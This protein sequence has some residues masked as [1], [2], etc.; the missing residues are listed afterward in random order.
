M[1]NLFRMHLLCAVLLALTIAFSSASGQENDSRQ[2]IIDLNQSIEAQIA[3]L[4]SRLTGNPDQPAERQ[5]AYH[6]WLIELYDSA[7]RPDDVMQSFEKIVSFFPYDVGILN[8]YAQYMLERRHDRDAAESLI[9]RARQFA[10]LIQVTD[11]DRGT[12]LYL[13]ASIDLDKKH[14]SNAISEFTTAAFLCEEAPGT[15]FA[16]LSGLT[17]A[18]SLAGRYQEAADAY[19]SLLGQKEWYDSYEMDRLRNLLNLAGTHQ[20][21]T[22]EQLIAAAVERERRKR[23]E[24]IEQEGAT[25]VSLATSRGLPL[26]GTLYEGRHPGAVIYLAPPAGTRMAFRLFSQLLFTEEISVLALDLRNTASTAGTSGAET[27]SSDPDQAQDAVAAAVSFMREKYALAGE[28]VVIISEGSVC[29]AVELAL[30]RHRLRCPVL[31]LSP[32]FDR[33]SRQFANAVPFR[34]VLPVMIIYS[35]EDRAALLSLERMR[36]LNTLP[37]LEIL[38]LEK[39]GHGAEMLKRS[40]QALAAFLS[41]IE[42]VLNIPK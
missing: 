35:I 37:T 11:V 21:L 30:F 20:T 31:H 1:L 10:G 3:D 2:G 27:D 13:Q 18:L 22:P 14:Y 15:H 25:L 34:P 26:E 5:A 39:A 42:G 16:A 6:L 38:E 28:Q 4:E 17:Q 33:R 24:Q 32:L 36:G 41:W 40:P 8:R 19:L 12:T 29:E 9:A 7:G 23:Q